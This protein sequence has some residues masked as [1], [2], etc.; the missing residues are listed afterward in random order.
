M[1]SIKFL[2]WLQYNKG[3]YHKDALDIIKRFN[4]SKE[5]DLDK[6]LMIEFL[7]CDVK[8]ETDDKRIQV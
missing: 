6:R 8:G 1:A 7:N 2:L 4:T 5:T 3:F